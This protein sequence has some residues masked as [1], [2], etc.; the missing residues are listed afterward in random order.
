MTTYP[1]ILVN[2]TV[3]DRKDIMEVPALAGKVRDAEA[4]LDGDGRLLIRYSGTEPK[5]RIMA[6]GKDKAVI[7]ALVQDLA[8]AVKEELG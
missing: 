3:K 1:Q 2:V 6:E 5:L 8:D 4:R 7:K